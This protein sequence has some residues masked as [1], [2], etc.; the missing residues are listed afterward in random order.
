MIA[1]SAQSSTSRLQDAPSPSIG[2]IAR[3]MAH[4][5]R[6]VL[7]SPQ[8]TSQG[9]WTAIEIAI[10]EIETSQGLVGFGE[11]LA[12]R[13]SQAYASFIDTVLAPLLVGEDPLDRRRLWRKLRGVHSGRTGGMLI[14]AIAGL[15][16]ALWDIAGKAAGQSVGKLL[17]GM[18]RTEIA[19]Y[20]SSINWLDD[21]T[22]EAEVAA[23]LAAGF[24]QI[25]V[26]IGAPIDAAIERVQLVRRLAGDTIGLS[27]DANWA[28]D[29]DAALRVGRVL[30]DLGYDWFE[31]PIRPEDRHGY[32]IL[33]EK[34]PVRLAAGE[35]DYV[36]TDA[37]ELL[38]DRSVGLIQPDVA[39]SGGISETW[40][41]AELAQ[42]HGVAYA[43]H[44]GWSGAVCVAASLQLAAAAENC[45]V[46]ECM[47][48]DNPLRQS[49][50]TSS[51]G[52]PAF[53]RDGC[54]PI[55]TGPGLGVEV[56]RAVLSEFRIG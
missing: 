8:R 18:G 15:D 23:A 13:G 14:E 4:P 49:L 27:V 55:P 11:C 37:L 39:R 56:D 52:D 9:D 42:S 33:R 53:M 16:I 47:V 6:A 24:K 21:E 17:G 10:V 44:V 48:Y 30:A 41:I 29:V 12:R 26:K 3:V 43:P 2:T 35:S 25:K 28:Y 7:P 5:L 36:A 51:A 1:S 38:Q 40:R 19:A 46:F 32:R 31:E 45:L 20:A 22:V 50:L 34:L 54:L